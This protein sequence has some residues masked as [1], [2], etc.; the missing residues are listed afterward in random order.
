VR[1][2]HYWLLALS[3]ACG[4]VS[5]VSH[6][7]QRTWIDSITS[8]LAA[9]FLTAFLI[10]LFIDRAL[11]RERKRQVY[12][13][14]ALALSQLP[15]FLATHVELLWGWY[16]AA[17]HSLPATPFGTFA[18]LFSDEYYRGIRYLDMSKRAPVASPMDWFEWNAYK[19]GEL[20]TELRRIADTYA[21]LVDPDT[22]A[23]LEEMANTPLMVLIPQFTGTRELDAREGYRRAY[24]FF[25]G[26]GIDTLVK[27]H[28]RSLLQL[29]DH[30][31]ANVAR[32][33]KVETREL[34]RNDIAPQVGSSRISDDHQ[35]GRT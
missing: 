5:F 19:F 17:V 12:R 2:Q 16:K 34:M 22:L 7:N 6:W 33:I 9:G 4:A 28:V 24:N 26:Q 3:I 30:V 15:R 35:D 11:D 18:E 14:R 29:I 21:A 23:M 27:E 8:N 31:N 13:T 1:K 20:R 32:P 10:V 25:A